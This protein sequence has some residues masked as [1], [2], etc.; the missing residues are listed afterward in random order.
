MIKLLTGRLDSIDRRET[1]HYLG[2]SAV[3]I[4]AEETTALLD[5]CEKE[6][7]AVQDLR[8]VYDIFDF[9]AQGDDLDLGFVRVRSHSLALNLAGCSK[10][11]LFACT[12]GVGVD[13][14]AAEYSRLSPARAAAVQ[15]LGG[16]LAEGWCE[17]IQRHIIAQYGANRTRFSCGYGDL[18]LT[19]QRD[20]FA[21][22]SVT[23]YIGVT[24]SDNCFMTPTK[25]V[26]AIAGIK[27]GRA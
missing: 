11:V 1:L 16:A 17:E 8:C 20:I 9:S 15:A 21:A 14:L 27:G 24:L 3:D 23:K 22:L 7:L 19:L 13:R 4:P 25:S 2:L 18:P 26:T 6:V 10:I 5:S 12:A